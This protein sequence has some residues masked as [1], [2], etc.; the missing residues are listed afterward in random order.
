LQSWSVS[1]DAGQGVT[2]M[3]SA[4]GRQ[5]RRHG[6]PPIT[7]IQAQLSA[8][9]RVRALRSWFMD[10]LN[11]WMFLLLVRMYNQK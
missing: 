2:A 4:A 8:K 7:E 11:Q 6:R 3:T 5:A 1:V 9:R 10:F